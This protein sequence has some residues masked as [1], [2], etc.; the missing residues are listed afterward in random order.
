MA[1]SCGICPMLYAQIAAM[2]QQ[3]NQLQNTVGMLR[4]GLVGTAL[5]IDQEL[6][7]P[8]MQ[9]QKVLPYVSMRLKDVAASV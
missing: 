2:Q 9:R 5:W 1:E 8:T 6:E 3:I 4:A 7:K